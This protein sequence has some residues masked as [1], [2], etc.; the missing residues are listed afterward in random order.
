MGVPIRQPPLVAQTLQLLRVHLG[1]KGK[2]AGNR[3]SKFNVRLL[4]R[5]IKRRK[6]TEEFTKEQEGRAMHSLFALDEKAREIVQS[7]RGGTEFV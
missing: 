4:G 6:F 3:E 5:R 7:R 2:E 1:G